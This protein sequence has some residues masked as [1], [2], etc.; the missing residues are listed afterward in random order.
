MHIPAT[1][2]FDI[3]RFL[4]CQS[5]A[6]KGL[7]HNLSVLLLSKHLFTHCQSYGFQRTCSQIVSLTA[8]KGLVHILSVLLLSKDLLPG[9]HHSKAYFELYKRLR[10]S[11]P[12]HLA[13]SISTLEGHQNLGITIYPLLSPST[14]LSAGL[15]YLLAHYVMAPLFWELPP[16]QGLCPKLKICPGFVDCI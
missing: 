16:N 12:S 8:F 5:T 11:I 13:Q 15:T 9:F 1:K 10:N 2:F 3:E 14:A 7:V 6:F 4:N